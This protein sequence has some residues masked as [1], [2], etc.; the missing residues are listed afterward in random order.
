MIKNVW[1]IWDFFIKK[2]KINYSFLD[3]SIVVYA[4]QHMYGCAL[5]LQ[6]QNIILCLWAVKNNN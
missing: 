1:P 2:I 6:L 3:R 5:W 4:M